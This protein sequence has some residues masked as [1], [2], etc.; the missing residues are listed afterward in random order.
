MPKTDIKSLS[1]ALIVNTRSRRGADLFDQAL[2]TLKAESF[3]LT[4][5]YPVKHPAELI[6]TVERALSEGA[7]LIILGSGDGTVSEVV[8]AL[9]HHKAILGFL[10]LGTTN[11]F[12][13]TL[14]I[15]LTVDGAIKTLH[16]GKVAKVG[17]GLVD[18]DYFANVSAI[19]LSAS[20]A[21]M[22]TNTQKRWLGRF[23]YLITGIRAIARQ[24][25]FK[26]TLKSAEG[27]LKNISA[28][29]IVIANGKFHAGREL[30]KGAH[31]AKERLTV[32][33]VE[34]T[35][36][37]QLI[38]ALVGYWLGIDAQLKHVTYFE[39]SSIEILTDPMQRLEIDGELKAETPVRVRLAPAALKVIVP[40]HFNDEH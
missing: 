38:S 16:T 33:Y 15:P 17:L 13:R 7:E 21:K 36:R 14:S 25:P 30:S 2:N 19:G 6:A 29:Q 35:S 12:V 1:A 26:A 31:I 37:W 11:N 34:G 22:V 27:T 20:I 4:A 32:Y 5:V 9:A 28:W 23:A 10:P 8:D 3:N 24:K 40:D 18:D 39:T